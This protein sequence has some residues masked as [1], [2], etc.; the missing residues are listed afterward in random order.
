MGSLYLLDVPWN[1]R[2][3]VLKCFVYRSL[4]S[5]SPRFHPCY[6]CSFHRCLLQGQTSGPF[7]HFSE[8]VYFVPWKFMVG[9][10]I[11]FSM[12]VP[13]S[14]SNKLQWALSNVHQHFVPLLRTV[15]FCELPRSQNHFSRTVSTCV[16]K[17]VI[18]AHAVCADMNGK[19]LRELKDISSYHSD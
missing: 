16:S 18:L 11:V 1:R 8:L 5:A 17:C 6:P 7:L 2:F 12:S 15:L 10:M 4:S 14:W 9:K 3:N 13:I 19:I